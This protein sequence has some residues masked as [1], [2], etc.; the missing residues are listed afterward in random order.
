MGPLWAK[1]I[2]R[3]LDRGPLL[4]PFG[5]DSPA[6]AALWDLPLTTDLALPRLVMESSSICKEGKKEEFS[7]EDGI[8]FNHVFKLVNYSC[9]FYNLPL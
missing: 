1:H 6:C 2:D 8:I 4:G 9:L 5:Q 3:R 7:V